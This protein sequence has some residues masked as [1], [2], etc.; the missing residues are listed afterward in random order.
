MACTG[1]FYPRGV[2][3]Q[4]SCIQKVGISQVENGT[5]CLSYAMRLESGS[6][7]KKSKTRGQETLLTEIEIR[8]FLPKKR[9]KIILF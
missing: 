5:V 8:V 2:P 6:L 7:Q 3:F 1:M 9:K 4:A